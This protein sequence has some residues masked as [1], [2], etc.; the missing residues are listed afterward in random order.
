MNKLLQS[1]SFDYLRMGIMNV[2]WINLILTMYSLERRTQKLSQI[3]SHL[4]F[5][6]RKFVYIQNHCIHKSSTSRSDYFIWNLRWEDRN[7]DNVCTWELFTLNECNK[8]IL[9]DYIRRL[10]HVCRQ[11]Y[12]ERKNDS[13]IIWIKLLNKTIF[14]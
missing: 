2:N 4:F 11:F 1:F 7:C 9:S 5:I 12:K 8:I 14:L 10:L 13:F 3:P 6:D